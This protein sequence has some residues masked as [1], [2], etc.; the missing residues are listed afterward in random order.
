MVKSNTPVLRWWFS[1]Q[2]LSSDSLPFM[3]TSSSCN[4]VFDVFPSFSGEDVRRTFLSHL[5]LSLDHKLITCF[6]DNEIER[7]QSIGLELVHAIR[8]SRIAIVILSKTYASSTWCLNELLEIVKCKEEKGQ[9][10]IPVFYGLEPSHVRKQTGEFGETFQ[11]ICKNRSD[12]LPDLWKG[13]LTHVANIHG[14]HSDNWYILLHFLI[15]VLRLG[16]FIGTRKSEP[17]WHEIEQKNYK[18]LDAS[19]FP[20]SERTGIEKNLWP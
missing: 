18:Y 9:M 8:D 11:M 10:V 6:K 15:L 20:L 4:W 13:A 2:N 19:I 1:S 16:H 3:A 7:S 5:L 17:I 12:E 14:Y